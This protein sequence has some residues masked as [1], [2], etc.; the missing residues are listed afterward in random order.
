MQLASRG[1][2]GSRTGLCG[3]P[4]DDATGESRLSR[5]PH[6]EIVGLGA[7]RCVPAPASIL[8]PY[9]HAAQTPAGFAD[10][11]RCS[12]A[13]PFA[14]LVHAF[15][16]TECAAKT[17]PRRPTRAADAMPAAHGTLFGLLSVPGPPL[18]RVIRVI[19]GP[20][21][22]SFFC[23]LIL[24]P[25]HG[26]LLREHRDGVALPL[27]PIFLAIVS[28]ET[29]PLAD[30]GG[31]PALRHERGHSSHTPPWPSIHA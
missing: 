1:Q 7:S 2:M 25:G 31:C 5:P 10:D 13:S 9:R 11:R 6:F 22:P 29:T 15:G 19:R 3:Q 27:C 20:F 17:I 14:G 21:L 18:I 28:V 26:P 4:L 24:L 30:D 23:G 16:V 12:R 8:P